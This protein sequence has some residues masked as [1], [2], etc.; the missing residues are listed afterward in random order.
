MRAAFA[1]VDVG[2]WENKEEKKKQAQAKIDDPLL[3]FPDDVDYLNE[4]ECKAKEQISARTGNVLSLEQRWTEYRSE[5]CLGKHGKAAMR[6][7]VNHALWGRYLESVQQG[8]PLPLNVVRAMVEFDLVRRKLYPPDYKGDGSESPSAEYT[9][10]LQ[11]DR[12][13]SEIM[14]QLTEI[15][16]RIQSG[17]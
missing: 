11:K 17:S 4:S 9:M 7:S 3:G 2:G 13:Y 8:H 10:Q 16:R 15:T 14:G 5:C 12:T 6:C 1:G